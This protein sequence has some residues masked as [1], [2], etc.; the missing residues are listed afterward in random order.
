MPSSGPTVAV[1]FGTFPP[2][3]NGGADFV[4]RFAG[5]LVRAGARVHVITSR[6]AGPDL[7]E[8]SEG[9]VVHR[10]VDDWTFRGVAASRSR[11][12]D[13]LATERADVLHVFF[14]DSVVGPDYQAAAFF[15]PRRTRLVATWWNL[16]LGRRSPARLR[17]GSA[18]LLTRSRVLSA[19][20]PAYVTALQRLVLGRK[21]VELLPVGSNF[22]RKE[23]RRRDGPHTL[24]FFGQLDFTRGVDT[25]FDAVARLAR[26]EVRLVMLGSAG[27]PQRYGDDPE[28]AR[29]LAL[30]RELGIEQQVEWTGFLSDDDVPQALA[31][32]DL[33]VLPYRRNSLG[34]SALAAA[35]DAGTPVVLGGRADRVA[36]LVPGEHIALVPPDDAQ[37]LADTLARLLDDD[38]ERLRLAAGAGRAAEFFAWTRI[39]EIALGLY[40]RALR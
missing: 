24:G 19:H 1:C 15:A 39:A 40:R 16:G 11:V 10:I 37:G 25:L 23:R 29:L 31:D 12:R 22:V 35:L 30:P 33:C 4:A 6:A 9:F 7:E 38:D 28:F 17:L 5:A 3:R 32:L 18:A 21:P 27:R 34:R 13:M 20:D 8:T 2:E 26:P 14:P 36:P